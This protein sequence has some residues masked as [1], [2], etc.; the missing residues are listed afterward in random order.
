MRI[1]LS[2]ILAMAFMGNANAQKITLPSKG[3]NIVY[4][5]S[6]KLDHNYNDLFV[7]NQLKNWAATVA[8]EQ[9]LNVQEMQDGVCTITIKCVTSLDEEGTF[10]DVYCSFTMTVS[11]TADG[12]DYK[13]SDLQFNKA[14]HSYSA[15]EV[16]AH[17]LQDIPFVKVGIEK[18]QAAIRRHGV[19]L[20]TLNKKMNGLVASFNSYMPQTTVAVNN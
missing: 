5:G 6:L 11:I 16:Y 8:R 13:V 10:K 9:H 19:L 1:L 12:L 15:N 7:C 3:N 20:E 14:N 17:Y 2:V 4:D 18:K